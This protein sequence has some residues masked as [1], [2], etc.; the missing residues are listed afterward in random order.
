MIM[1]IKIQLWVLVVFFVDIWLP[2]PTTV[3]F[4]TGII[5]NSAI[6]QYTVRLST[7]KRSAVSLASWSWFAWQAVAVKPPN[8]ELIKKPTSQLQKNIDIYC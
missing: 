8:R 6:V 3:I 2:K 7:L 1:V 4:I 5:K